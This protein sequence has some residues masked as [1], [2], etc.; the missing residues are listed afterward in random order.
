MT[1]PRA[2]C[3]PDRTAFATFGRNMIADLAPEGRVQQHLAQRVSRIACR[4]AFC[5]MLLDTLMTAMFSGDQL[6]T[7][8]FATLEQSTEAA[9]IPA[10][11]IRELVTGNAATT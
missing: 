2:T 11:N 8:S 5:D 10:K 1:T 4:L 6:P 9:G 7:E 3:E